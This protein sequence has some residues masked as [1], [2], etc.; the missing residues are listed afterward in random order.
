MPQPDGSWRSQPRPP[1]WRHT[2][3]DRI[4]T[5]DHHT[6]QWPRPQGICGTPANQVDHI[7]PA[8]LGGTDDDDNLQAL[9]PH[10][11]NIKSG[12]EGGQAAAAKRIPKRRPQDKHPGL[13]S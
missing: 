12:R 3:R 13:L 2:T 9:C 10:H 5:R 1:G 4:L 11:H 6:C 7:T 8:W